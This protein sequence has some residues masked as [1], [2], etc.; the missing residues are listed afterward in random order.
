MLLREY[1]T[2]SGCWQRMEPRSEVTEEDG[3]LQD[4][5]RGGKDGEGLAYV[6][7]RPQKRWWNCCLQ[8]AGFRRSLFSAFEQEEWPPLGKVR[9][10]M[11]SGQKSR[12]KLN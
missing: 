7:G 8:L 3:S 5:K 4:E 2:T 9:L 12:F 11:A 6:S 10:R 1:Q